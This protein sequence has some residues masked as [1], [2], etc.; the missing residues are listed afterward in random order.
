MG[1]ELYNADNKGKKR[2]KCTFMGRV[3][4]RLW[5]VDQASVM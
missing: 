5:D 3:G 4:E 1:A 2:L